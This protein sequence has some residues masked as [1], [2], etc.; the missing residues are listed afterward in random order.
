MNRAILSDMLGKRYEIICASDGDEAIEILEKSAQDISLLLLDSSMPAVDGFGVLRIMNDRRWIDD[1]P[2]LMTIAEKDGEIIDRA[3]ELGV[4]DFI[5][6]PFDEALI[7]RRVENTLLLNSRQDKLVEIV[8]DRLCKIQSLSGKRGLF[9]PVFLRWLENIYNGQGPRG[10]SFA[11][12]SS[13]TDEDMLV[14]LVK[15]GFF[16][17]RRSLPD[18][19]VQLIEKEREKYRFFSALTQEI[20]F[21]YTASPSRLRISEYGAKRLGLDELIPAPTKNSAVRSVIGEEDFERLIACISSATPDAPTVNMECIINGKGLPRWHRIIVQTLWSAEEP[22]RFTGAI[23]KTIDINDFYIKREELENRASRDSLTGMLNHASAR[24]KIIDCMENEPQAKY[25]LVIFDLDSFKC[26]NDNYGHSFGDETLKHIAKKLKKS[27]RAGDIAA[28][29]GG[30]EFLIF[31]QYKAKPEPIIKRI[32]GSLMGEFEQF[33]VSVSMGVAETEK[34]GEDYQTL[35]DAADRALYYAK[36][37]GKGIYC[38]Y[39]ESMTDVF[40]DRTPIESDRA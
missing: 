29:V 37:D 3:I 24:K 36:R 35:F 31:I 1:I 23:G 22:R 38:F 40:S 6:R 19:S 32:H 26:A 28:R 2:V 5:I 9:D 14:R 11:V 10:E 20:E 8:S 16:A 25:A 34:V 15:D 12:E 21:E 30:D 18:R 17:E 33:T 27:I 13:D 7:W 4:T 39:D